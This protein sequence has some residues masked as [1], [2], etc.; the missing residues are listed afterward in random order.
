MITCMRTFAAPS[1]LR[2]ADQLSFT[3]SGPIRDLPSV[4]LRKW[5]DRIAVL[6]S[7]RQS[8]VGEAQIEKAKE[9]EE[10]FTIYNCCKCACRMASLAN[11]CTLACTF[12]F[13]SPSETMELLFAIAVPFL[14]ERDRDE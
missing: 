12:S 5:Q 2:A 7:E 1:F 10:S 8:K 11:R 9:H 6:W 13:F 3:N 14:T 4:A